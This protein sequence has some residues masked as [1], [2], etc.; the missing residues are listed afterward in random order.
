MPYTQANRRMAINTSLGEDVL[1][2]TSFS[3]AEGIS[4]PFHFEVNMVSEQENLAFDSVVG[5]NATVRVTLPD[6]TERYFN[7]YVANFT[8]GG[9]DHDFVYYHAELVPWLWFLTQTSDCRIFQDKT[10]PDII[11]QIFG[12]YG[13]KDYSLKLYGSFVKR[14]YCVQYRETGH[15]ASTTTN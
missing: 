15:S 1:L 6:G 13:L 9:R 2:I 12:E 14:I 10:V 11:E 8:Q 5:E 3:G 4:R 7:G